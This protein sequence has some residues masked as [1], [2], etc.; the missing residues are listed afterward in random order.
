MPSTITLTVYTFDELDAKAKDKARE[1]FRS[2]W[3]SNDTY[4]ITETILES[5]KA[6]GCEVVAKSL[7]WNL[8]QDYRGIAFEG[9]IT[10]NSRVYQ[11]C[12][13][14]SGWRDPSSVIADCE[15]Y[16]LRDRLNSVCRQAL[17]DGQTYMDYLT[18]GESVDESIRCNEY[19][20]TKEGNREG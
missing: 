6:Q 7:E 10:I 15:D 9:E 13:H 11:V 5:L 8:D 20:F 16:T 19:T 1:W 3:S 2:C 17:K 12:K 4:M 18:F 14:H